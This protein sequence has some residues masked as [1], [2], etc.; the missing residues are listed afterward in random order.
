MG[1]GDPL[2]GWKEG[3]MSNRQINDSISFLTQSHFSGKEAHLQLAMKQTNPIYDELKKHSMVALT[4]S[5]ERW[6]RKALHPADHSLKAQRAP[7]VSTTPTASQETI[8]VFEVKPP[9]NHTTGKTWGFRIMMNSDP[10]CPVTTMNWDTGGSVQDIAT[11]FNVA[12]TTPSIPTYGSHTAAQ[13]LAVSDNVQAAGEEYRVNGMSITGTFVGATVTDQGTIVAGQYSDPFIYTVHHNVS[14]PTSGTIEKVVRTWVNPYQPLNKL[15]AGTQP[16][17]T[18]AKKGFYMPLK[19]DQTHHWCRTDNLCPG[20]RVPDF[21]HETYVSDAQA[22]PILDGNA[23]G[24]PW[25]DPVDMNAGCVIAEGLDETTTFRMTLRIS[26]EMK[27]QPSS[28]YTPFAEEPVPPDPFALAM[29]TQIVG[30]MCDAY[31]SDDNDLNE[32]WYKIQDIAKKVW[33][34]AD[35]ALTLLSLVP[36]IAPITGAIK[37]VASGVSTAANAINKLVPRKP[38]SQNPSKPKFRPVAGKVKVKKD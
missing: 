9:T 2:M 19:I 24:T 4:L 8:T 1:T 17:I 3:H 15:T 23:W 26:L 29:Y 10:F 5:G 34:I 36:P 30:R 31:P 25:F 35:P 7:G 27:T 16:Y 12:F 14:F 13:Y 11:C 22:T 38:V 32:L 6:V 20:T 28:S 21:T 33:K 37:G 18:H